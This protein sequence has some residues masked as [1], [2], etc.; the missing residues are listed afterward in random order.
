V[1]KQL[2]FEI[3][4]ENLH[5]Y[6]LEG[7]LTPAY[8]VVLEFKIEGW[9]ELNYSY[10]KVIKSSDLSFG[11]DLNNLVSDH[12]WHENLQKTSFWARMSEKQKEYVKKSLSGGYDISSHTRLEGKNYAV[13]IIHLFATSE[14][15]AKLMAN[16]LIEVLNRLNKDRLIKTQNEAEFYTKLVQAEKDKIA[17]ITDELPKA[18]AEIEKLQATF[19]YTNPESAFAE[20]VEMDKLVR[21]IGID[22]AG[23]NARMSAIQT[24]EKKG[25]EKN[26]PLLDQRRV[27]LNIEMAGLLA[28][29]KAAEDDR[30]QAKRYYDLLQAVE[31]DQSV[32]QAETNKL[33]DHTGTM[34]ILKE[35]LADPPTP[36]MRPVM[37]LDNKA[38]IYHLVR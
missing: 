30:D 31:T 16:A 9:H 20:F 12:K 8:A 17:Q 35:K 22:I 24:I 32:L 23:V 36:L 10:G 4:K 3:S 14:D 25:N 15:D 21:I 13:Y 1:Q 7:P 2:T 34:M 26:Q 29:K 28:R 11:T 18:K 38:V 5:H 33:K 19:H 6:S 37:P 27:D